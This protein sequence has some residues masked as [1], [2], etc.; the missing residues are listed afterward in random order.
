[1]IAVDK[2]QGAAHWASYLVNG[3]DSG[4]E[5][6]ERDLADAWLA[7]LAPAYVVS[8]ED[9]SF[10]SWSYGEI[11]GDDSC[12]G[13]T[14]I[15]YVTHRPTPSAWLHFGKGSEPRQTVKVEARETDLPRT[16]R[17][18]HGY[19]A[20]IPTEWLV[21]WD[22]RWRRVY[23]ACYGNSPSL[24]IGPSGDWLATVDVERAA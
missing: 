13:G 24:Y 6:R 10:F 3:D 19:G 1:M 7:R 11:C 15:E 22:G 5:P 18:I 16:R 2:A 20:R 17:P 14:L 4:L 9:E 12:S 23:A 8:C 21:L